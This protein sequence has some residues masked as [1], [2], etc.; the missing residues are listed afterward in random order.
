MRRD[1][2]RPTGSLTWADIT[3]QR[4][5][6]DRGLFRG[7]GNA[8]AIMVPVGAIIVLAVIGAVSLLP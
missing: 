5:D 1:T 2:I 6:D 7:L 3:G 4:D 8:L